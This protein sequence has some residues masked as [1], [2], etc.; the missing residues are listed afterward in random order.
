MAKELAAMSL[1]ILLISFVFTVA[2]PVGKGQAPPMKVYVDPPTVA[3]ASLVPNT[4][5]NVSV[6]VD[7][8]PADPGVAGI[9]FQ[10]SWNSSLLKGV[11]M[12]E[13]I[14]HETMPPDE[15]SSN[16]WQLTHDVAADGVQYAYTYR[17][18]RDALSGGYAP[19]NGSHTVAIIT[20]KVVGTGECSIHFQ[21]SIFGDP[22]GLPVAHELY[23]GFF[24][25]LSPPPLPKAAL[26][27][28]DP[29]R[30][31]NSSLTPAQNFTVNINI[32]NASGLSGLEFKLG[33]N[34][35]VLRANSVAGGSFVPGSVTPVTQVDNTAAFVRF[36]VSLSTPLSGNGT[37]AVIQFQVQADK[38]WNSSLHLYD[39]TLVGATGQALPF[40]TVDGSFTNA[41]TLK[42][43]LNGDGVVDIKDA[44]LAA[45]AYG[46]SPGDPNW[47][48]DADLDGNGTVNII[49]LILLA[50]NF[51]QRA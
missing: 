22:N 15:I 19:I 8:I 44:I 34:A 11:S 36:N 1:A 13:V 32:V 21:T 48:P 17:N 16:L 26:L 20:L 10:L 25:N 41:R 6:K 33:F 49:D 30:I 14:F 28:V 46:S 40:T 50:M 51:G 4:T 39:V 23:D 43:D 37:L 47:N 31:A 9:Q 12:E 7:N 35:S 2:M 5:F 42:G 3:N 45:R 29:A 38:V 24:S 27:Y 18:T